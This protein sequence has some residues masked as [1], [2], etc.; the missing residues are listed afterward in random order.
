[1]VT[2][3]FCSSRAQ[4][5]ERFVSH[6][7]AGNGLQAASKKHSGEFVGLGVRTLW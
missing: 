2:N 1:M 4:A 3:V 7:I 6:V 5:G